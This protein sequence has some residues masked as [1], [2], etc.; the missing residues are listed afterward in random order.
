M[1]GELH[2]FRIQALMLQIAWIRSLVSMAHKIYYNGNFYE[3]KL[4]LM[5]DTQCARPKKIIDLKCLC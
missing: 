4:L 3:Y 2:S 5:D 1:S